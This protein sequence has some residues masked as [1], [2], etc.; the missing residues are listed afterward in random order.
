MR[1]STKGFLA[2]AGLAIGLVVTSAAAQNYTAAMDEAQWHRLLTHFERVQQQI[3]LAEQSGAISP[4]QAWALQKEFQ[5]VETS[6]LWQKFEPTGNNH[7]NIWLHLHHIHSV[8]G[9]AWDRE[10]DHS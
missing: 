9:G 2:A 10:F 3:D 4:A 6:A 1:T 7:Y 8:L 5:G